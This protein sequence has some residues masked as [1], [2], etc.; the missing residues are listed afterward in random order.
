[1][2]I[3]LISENINY[4]DRKH[5][6]LSSLLEFSEYLEQLH[7]VV[8]NQ[9]KPINNNEIINIDGR[10]FIYP[11]NYLNPLSKKKDFLN[12]VNLNVKWTKKLIVDLILSENMTDATYF[13][14]ELSQK[15]KVPLIIDIKDDFEIDE[16]ETNDSINLD[17]KII[18]KGAGGIAIQ[19]NRVKEKILKI[20]PDFGE[21]IFFVEEYVN[22]ESIDKKET[23]VNLYQR[24]P[25]AGFFILSELNNSNLFFYEKIFEGIINLN[26]NYIKTSLL[27]LGKNKNASKIW[28]KGSDLLKERFFWEEST[29]NLYDYLKKANLFIVNVHS[30]EFN[31]KI[32]VSILSGCPVMAQNEGLAKTYIDEGYTGYIFEN[33][34]THFENLVT[35]TVIDIIRD[36]NIRDKIILSY[37]KKLI[38]HITTNKDEFYQ[39][40]LSSLQDRAVFI[41][42]N[43]TFYGY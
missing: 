26:K 38:K 36:P 10:V 43:Q 22:F 42:M 29:E 23:K 30:G 32:M 37:R 19:S 9:R 28:E 1:M 8:I 3:L 4:L 11:T 12:V 40:Y 39:K 25:Q 41:D 27:L 13:A 24:Y 31:K 6:D 7:V 5:P 16:V 14:Y 34:L 18:M 35:K 21:K 33:N 17:Y 2:K 20:N 15:N